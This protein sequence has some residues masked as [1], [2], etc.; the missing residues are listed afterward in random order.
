MKNVLKKATNKHQKLSPNPVFKLFW[1]TYLCPL[2]KRINLFF[3]NN[4]TIS[5]DLKNRRDMLKIA[6]IFR[7]Y[8]FLLRVH[9][10]QKYSFT[11]LTHITILNQFL[12]HI[13]IFAFFHLKKPNLQITINLL[14][15][16]GMFSGS[17]FGDLS[18]NP[19]GGK[20]YILF[21][22]SF[23]LQFVLLFWYK[24][25]MYFVYQ[26]QQKLYKCYY[27]GIWLTSN[28]FHEIKLLGVFKKQNMVKNVRGTF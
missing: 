9:F 26:D 13:N 18:S 15:F 17:G 24:Y 14:W 4:L 2:G 12:A 27:Y 21:I 7:K 6:K 25:A 28:Q 8:L 11:F 19:G 16:I 23:G 20:R 5:S 22:Y 3:N 10:L 1:M